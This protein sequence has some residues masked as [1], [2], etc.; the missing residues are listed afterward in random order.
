MFSNNLSLMKAR[1]IFLLALLVLPF[2]GGLR[3]AAQDLDPANPP[4]PY[5]RYRLTTTATPYGYTYGAGSYLSGTAVNVRTSAY[6]QNYKFSHWTLNGEY[7]GDA[8]SFTYVMPEDKAEFVAV[9]DYDPVDP[10][11]PLPNYTHRLFLTN[12]MTPACSFNISSGTKVQEEAWIYIQAYVNSGYDF[13]GWYEG[14]RLVSESPAFNY[15]MGTQS[16]TLE[17]KFTYNPVNPSEPGSAPGQD[18]IANTESGDVDGDGTID[19]SDKVMLVNHYLDGTTSELPK[20]G[21]DVNGD[22]EIDIT[23]A[24][25]I[26]NKYLNNRQ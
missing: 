22:G 3:G 4:E 24:V 2:V 17:A 11:E 1:I 19:I 18:D 9:Y 12:N 8:M 20:D 5:T 26:V 21:A 7:Y 25:E 14:G 15:Q 16:V 10:A 6:S 13:V 23:D